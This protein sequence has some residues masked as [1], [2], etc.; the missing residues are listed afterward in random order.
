[1]TDKRPPN[2]DLYRLLEV[3]PTATTREIKRAYLEKIQIWHPDR[4]VPIFEDYANDVMKQL[5]YAREWL[6]DDKKRRAYDDFVQRSSEF[7]EASAID[8]FRARFSND[9]ADTSRESL[10]TWLERGIE[11]RNYLKLKLSY[12][13]TKL[14]NLL[15]ST[16]SYS[17]NSFLDP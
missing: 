13:R 15:N 7:F 8:R 4:A 17:S 6:T 3:E 10:D 11:K 2:I 16:S 5:N 14:T 1:M 12:S 9:L